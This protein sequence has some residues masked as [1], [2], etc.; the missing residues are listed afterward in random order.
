MKLIDRRKL[1]RLLVIQEISQRQLA[2]DIGWKSH[3]YLGR[4]LRGEVDTLEPEAALRIAERLKVGVDDLFVP[5]V[6]THSAQPARRR[7]AA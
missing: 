6:S 5:R 2:S 1:A 3:S 4:L 7:S